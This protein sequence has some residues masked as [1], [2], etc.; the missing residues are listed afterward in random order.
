MSFH[1]ADIN[2]IHSYGGSLVRE[3]IGF[4]IKR[5]RVWLPAGLLLS[6]NSG[7]VI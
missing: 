1:A 2:Q 5:L 4:V 3:G 7:Q 6:N